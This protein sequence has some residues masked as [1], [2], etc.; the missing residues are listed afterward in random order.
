MMG[1][2]SN[3][4]LDESGAL[5]NLDHVRFIG[6]FDAK[7]FYSWAAVVD[8]NEKNL[9]TLQTCKDHTTALEYC[10]RLAMRLRAAR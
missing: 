7:V 1:R 5:I 2:R 6:V 4:I 9:I 3:W 8:L 10:A